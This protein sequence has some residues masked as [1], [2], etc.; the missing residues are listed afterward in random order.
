MKVTIRRLPE[1]LEE[2]SSGLDLSRPEQTCALLLEALNLWLRDRDAGHQALD[3][4]RGPKPML[5]YDQQFLRDRMRGKEYLA[6]AYFEGAGPENGYASQAPYTLEV[7]PDTHPAQEGYCK[8]FLVT[9]GADSPRPVTL[10]R[11][12]SSWYL[13]EYSSIL[14]GIRL[15]AAEDP[16][17]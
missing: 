17:A 2:F 13:W 12:G 5:P 7:I 15:P 1:T 6:G 10:R 11:K 14:T 9:A 16:W 4:L 8:L 3:L